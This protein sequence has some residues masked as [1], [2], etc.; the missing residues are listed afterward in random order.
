MLDVLIMPSLYLSGMLLEPTFASGGYLLFNIFNR[1]EILCAA[2]VL[3]SL[4]IVQVQPDGSWMRSKPVVYAMLLLGM[5]LI[6]T[7]GLTP[8][9][10]A[11]AMDLDL[12]NPMN[13]PSQFE[14]QS[15]HFGYLGLELAKL[16]TG[17]GVFRFCLQQLTD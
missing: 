14:M 3:T 2:M 16:I 6:S 7:Y 13:V 8:A 5:T 15:L 11:T 17:L 4:L 10:S 9:M 12:F 1:V